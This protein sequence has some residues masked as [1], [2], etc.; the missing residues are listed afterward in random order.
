MVE[1]LGAT[2]RTTTEWGG[3]AIAL[4]PAWEEAI[5]IGPILEET[6]EV[7]PEL[8]VDD[9]SRDG[10]A[11]VAEAAGSPVVRHRQNRG[12]DAALRRGFAWAPDRTYDAVLTLNADGQHDPADIPKFLSAYQAGAAWPAESAASLS[13]VDCVRWPSQRRVALKTCRAVAGPSS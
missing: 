9:G 5:L 6:R 7:L 11:A 1:L 3:R 2:P 12:K 4:F 10:A 8:V 13:I